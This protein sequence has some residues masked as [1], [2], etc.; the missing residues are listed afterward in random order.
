MRTTR[1]H[2][3][4][5]G[6]MLGG[7]LTIRVVGV[8]AVE[9]GVVEVAV[10]VVVGVAAGQCHSPHQEGEVMRCPSPTPT[11]GTPCSGSDVT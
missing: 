6:W 3:G 5:R 7:A 11:S 9:V 1:P 10:E 8:V 2:V 4:V